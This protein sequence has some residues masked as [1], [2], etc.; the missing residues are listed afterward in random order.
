L[1]FKVENNYTTALNELCK[2]ISRIGDFDWVE[3]WTTN[4][5]KSQMLLFSHY[6]P[7]PNDETFYDD[8]LEIYSFK[9]DEG[10]VGKVWSQGTGIF[11]NDIKHYHEF[12]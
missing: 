9:M 12:F 2:S 7:D 3:L 6:M 10:L 8:G 5:E 1:D 11:W 4:L